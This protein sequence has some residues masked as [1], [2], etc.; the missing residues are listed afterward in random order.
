MVRAFLRSFLLSFAVIAHA[1]CSGSIFDLTAATVAGRV[2]RADDTVVGGVV[3]ALVPEGGS[4]RKKQESSNE[5]RRERSQGGRTP[6]QAPGQCSLSVV[7]SH[8]S[9]CPRGKTACEGVAA[10]LDH[11]TR[12]N[13]GQAESSPRGRPQGFS[14]SRPSR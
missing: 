11:A 13:V 5:S 7:R 6:A 14:R 3:K 4:A 9:R 8:F 1:R 12:A 10:K 2:C